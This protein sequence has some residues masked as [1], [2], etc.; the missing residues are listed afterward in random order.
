MFCFLCRCSCCG[1]FSFLATTTHFTWV[2]RR[3]AVFGQGADRRSFNHWRSNFG[4]HRRFNHWRSLNDRSWLDHWGWLS[5]HDFGNRCWRFFYHWG[6]FWR[7][8]RSGRF[9]S[10]LEGGLFFTNF[11]SFT[12]FWR[13][14]DS[15]CFNNGFNHWLG[16]NYRCGFNR[17]HFNFWLGFRSL[18]N[19]HFR[20][21]RRF[22]WGGGFYNRCFDDGSFS[23]RRFNHRCFND[24]RLGNRCLH[25]GGF[26]DSGSRAFSLLVSLGFS[27]GADDRAGN[28]SGNGQASSQ[29]GASW[30]AG[31]GFCVFAGLFR[32][33]DHV[34]V[35]ITLTLTTV[36]ATT[37][38]TGAAAWT[39]AFGAFLAVFLQLLFAGQYF[40]FAGGSSLFGT[41]LTLFTRCARLTF[42]TW[43]TLFTRLASRALFSSNGSAGNGWR[44]VQWLAQFTHTLFTLATWLAVFAR[45]TW[46]TFFTRSAGGAFFA[47]GR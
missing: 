9:G 30:F 37:L 38:A 20:N 36:A 7:F 27:R 34:A 13:C 5:H 19:F 40:F 18:R 43:C 45:R 28:G 17:G 25:C 14:F 1:G 35:G 44:G 11:A 47:S 23:N 6:R 21:D 15:R 39:I 2:V 41:W 29:F 33:F 32:A 24:W 26:F 22:D 4:Y 46:C 10:P 42:F 12:Y 8:N 31:S 16:L 3:T